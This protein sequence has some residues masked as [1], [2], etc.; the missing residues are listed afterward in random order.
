MSLSGTAPT[1]DGCDRE[2]SG[3][4]HRTGLDR[5]CAPCHQ[6]H[7][8]DHAPADADEI[9]ALRRELRALR[10][11]VGALSATAAGLSAEV[12][13]LSRLEISLCGVR[14]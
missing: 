1:C 13:R 8:A 12:V 9:A 10:G 7:L 2:I 5:L 14:T 6:Q 11:Q 4:V 3:P